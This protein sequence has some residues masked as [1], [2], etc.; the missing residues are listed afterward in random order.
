[1]LF[2]KQPDCWEDPLSS[3]VQINIPIVHAVSSGTQKTVCLI[4]HTL[5]WTQFNVLN[6]LI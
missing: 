4:I 2:V 6:I 1:M 3:T 5:F